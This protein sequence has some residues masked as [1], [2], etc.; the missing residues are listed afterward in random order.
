ME[1]FHS[2]PPWKLILKPLLMFE[3]LLG[4]IL[5]FNRKTPQDKE[6]VLA[7]EDSQ[8]GTLLGVVQ[9]STISQGSEVFRLQSQPTPPLY[10]IPYIYNLAVLPQ[11]RRR[12][13][14]R[15][16]LEKC[17]QIV[18]EEWK[19]SRVGLH[20]LVGN[21]GAERLYKSLGYSIKGTDPPWTTFLLI[22]RRNYWE[23]EW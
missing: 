8:T 4:L 12:G 2:S 23:K 21:E 5:L 7:A 18:R 20:S 14:G 22:P 6:E 10:K 3:T 16:L 15:S 13:I 17:E 1:C 19:D 11:V 9:L